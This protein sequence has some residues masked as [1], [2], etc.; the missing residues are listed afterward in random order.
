MEINIIIIFQTA[1]FLGVL[2][3]L[4]KFLFRPMM[5]I[6][7]ER[8]KR[9]DGAKEEAILLHDQ[10]H[11][12]ISEVEKKVKIAQAQAREAMLE[13][14]HQAEIFE[15]KIMQ[16][17]KEKAAK[18]LEEACIKIDKDAAMAKQILVKE[19][20]DFSFSIAGKLA[21]KPMQPVNFQRSNIMSEMQ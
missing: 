10:A 5:T 8:E 2:L 13:M 6:F 18:K 1:L 21:D 7:D 19:S 4:S 20:K 14:K 15:K 12:K 16:D 17:A 3:W 9:I 11:D